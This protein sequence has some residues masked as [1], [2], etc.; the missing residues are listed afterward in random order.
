MFRWLAQALILTLPALASS[1]NAQI[2]ASIKASHHL[3]CGTVQSV[4][5]WN[6]EDV[7]GDLSA[8]G[9]EI[10]RAVAVAILGDSEGLSVHA[11]PAEPEALAALKAGEIQLAVGVSPSATVATRFD[12][13]FGP[14]VFYDSQRILVAKQSGIDDLAGLRDRLICAMDM[15]RPSGHCATN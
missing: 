1:A 9:G 14:P 6:G 3:D 13:D 11:Y 5:D 8:L 2:L 12:V 7:H 4:D 15:S 10:C